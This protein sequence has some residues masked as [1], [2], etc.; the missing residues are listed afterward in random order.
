[1]GLL[2]VVDE[3]KAVFPGLVVS[4]FARRAVKCVTAESSPGRVSRVFEF[5]R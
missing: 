3:V 4:V 1:M 5:T 2:F